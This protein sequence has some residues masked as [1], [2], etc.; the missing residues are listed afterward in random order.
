[1]T[2][3]ILYQAVYWDAIRIIANHF[4]DQKIDLEVTW[5]N[6]E[7]VFR[8]PK[9]LQQQ[10]R[11]YSVESIKDI[12]GC[13]QKAVFH[14]I[15]QSLG[16]TVLGEYRGKKKAENHSIFVKGSLS[17]TNTKSIEVYIMEE[18]DKCKPKSIEE[19][20][21][22]HSVYEKVYIIGELVKC[23][24]ITDAQANLERKI[25][26]LSFFERREVYKELIYLQHYYEPFFIRKL[27]TL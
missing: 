24:P 14:H 4:P 2:K 1:M 20:Q 26:D 10:I 3:D 23:E 22:L 9:N 13:S 21:L 16:T 7:F 6:K 27:T 18:L 11:F 12:F 17:N 8:G 19:V 15:L 5:K 25:Q